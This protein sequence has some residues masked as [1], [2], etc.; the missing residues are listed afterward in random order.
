MKHP[1]PD[2]NTTLALIISAARSGLRCPGQKVREMYSPNVG[3]LAREGMIRNEIFGRNYRVITILKGEHAGAHTAR[4]SD[5]KPPWMIIDT[6]GNHTHG[7]LTSKRIR[8]RKRRE[9]VV[10][11]RLDLKNIGL[12]YSPLTNSTGGVDEVENKEGPTG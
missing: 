3:R 9:E 10:R 7:V 6:R 11:H 8:D 5:C 1:P 2:I 12:A 4:H